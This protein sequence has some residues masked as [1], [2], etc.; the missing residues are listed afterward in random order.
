MQLKGMYSV[1]FELQVLK[2]LCKKAI[3]IKVALWTKKVLIQGNV[4][5]NDNLMYGEVSSHLRVTGTK[6][7]HYV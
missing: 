3:L 2:V 4:V 6:W 1:I 5:Y 7:F